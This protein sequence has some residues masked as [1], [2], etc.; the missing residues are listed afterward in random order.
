VQTLANLM[1]T[2]MRANVS[3][4][5]RS[6]EYYAE[7][8]SRLARLP[9]VA[10]VRVE[11]PAVTVRTNPI[12]RKIGGRT[13]DIGDFEITIMLTNPPVMRNV[14]DTSG[15]SEADHPLFI[16]GA[17]CLG[18]IAPMVNDALWHGE[19]ATAFLLL[20]LFLKHGEPV[21]LETA[22]RWREVTGSERSYGSCHS[23][24]DDH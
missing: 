5:Y 23:S 2:H 15:G 3:V 21:S 14:R 1:L 22:S 13:F 9:D 20:I 8:Y 10:D 16:H 17:Y 19:L 7:D 18:S 12:H 6:H 24:S 11:G 4:G